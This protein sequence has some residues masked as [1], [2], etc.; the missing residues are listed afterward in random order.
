MEPLEQV[1]RRALSIEEARRVVF[2]PEPEPADMADYTTALSPL[3]AGC[4][5]THPLAKV[6]PLKKRQLLGL[7]YIAHRHDPTLMR[8]W[9]VRYGGL[10]ALVGLLAT[11]NDYVLSQ[12]TLRS[13]RP[14]AHG[15]RPRRHRT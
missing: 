7:L 4:P 14:R 11:D 2:S 5:P 1:L 6:R 9:L 15:A 8:A 10:R 13:R 12:A 3:P